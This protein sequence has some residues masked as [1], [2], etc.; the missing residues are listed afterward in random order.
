MGTDGRLSLCRGGGCRGM[1]RRDKCGFSA[2]EQRSGGVGDGVKS[3]ER[4][5]EYCQ[6]CKRKG[7]ERELESEWGAH[8]VTIRRSLSRANHLTDWKCTM[9]P[10]NDSQKLPPVPVLNTDYST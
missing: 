9:L 7:G 5:K 4:A 1:K 6:K 8:H 2:L 3:M 10:E